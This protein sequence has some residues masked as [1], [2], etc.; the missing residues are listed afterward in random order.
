M[1]L[2]VAFHTCVTVG[3]F[4]YIIGGYRSNYEDKKIYKY[5]VLKDSY[6]EEIEFPF[7]GLYQSTTYCNSNGKIYISG[8]SNNPELF[9]SY[10]PISTR[11]AQFY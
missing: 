11:V 7:S 1:P 6:E 5:D 4:I 10:D 8:G 2:D 9:V 3:N